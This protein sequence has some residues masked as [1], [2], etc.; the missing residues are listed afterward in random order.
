MDL[1]AL[2]QSTDLWRNLVLQR[3]GQSSMLAVTARLESLSPHSRMTVFLAGLLDTHWA[4]I[5]ELYLSISRED[6][7]YARIVEPLRR[8]ADNLKVFVLRAAAY[9]EFLPLTFKLFRGHAPHLSCLVIPNTCGGGNDLKAPSMFTRNLRHLI[10]PQEIKLTAIDLLNACVDMPLLETINIHLSNL[11]FDDVI[12]LDSLPRPVMSRL[13][14][15]AITCPTLNIFPAFLDRVVPSAGCTLNMKQTLSSLNNCSDDDSEIF[16]HHIHRVLYRHAHSTVPRHI[17]QGRNQDIYLRFS[18]QE[19]AFAF[20]C[21]VITLQHVATS[22]ITPLL[23]IISTLTTR[24][25]SAASLFD[26]S[27]RTRS[28]GNSAL[29]LPTLAGL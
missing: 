12:D 27:F 4:R 24:E 2:D 17:V 1:E 8:P 14:S 9:E 15:I 23:E 10:L 28:W 25:S 11:V 20:G 5:G 7:E 29:I 16:G 26:L 22:L 18:A 19:F 13:N 21:I 6:P 3:A